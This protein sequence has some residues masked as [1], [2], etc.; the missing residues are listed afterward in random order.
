M[1]A[2]SASSCA[3]NYTPS[4]AAKRAALLERPL[5]DLLVVT[6]FDLTL[7]EGGSDQCHDVLGT[8]ECMPEGVRAA[9]SQLLDFSTPFPPHLQREGWWHRANDILSRMEPRCASTCHSSCRARPSGRG[10][11]RS[12]SWPSSPRSAFR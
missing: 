10:R 1:I 12:S 2:R 9:F 7:T 6:D 8:A 4:Y 11:A 5:S 3:F